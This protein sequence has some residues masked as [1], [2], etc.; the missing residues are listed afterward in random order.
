MKHLTFHFKLA[1][2]LKALIDSN[3]SNRFTTSYVHSYGPGAVRTGLMHGSG[4]GIQNPLSTRYCLS[5]PLA[6]EFILGRILD[7]DG[8]LSRAYN[9]DFFCYFF[10]SRQKS[11]APG[12]PNCDCCFTSFSALIFTLD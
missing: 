11:K 5:T 7:I 6:W 1:T 3:T 8:A 9:L 2:P 12:Y 4:V 10:V